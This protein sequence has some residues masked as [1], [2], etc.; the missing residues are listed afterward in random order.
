MSPQQTIL[1]K[2]CHACWEM[3]SV[4]P[5]MEVIVER[6]FQVGI[7]YAAGEQMV[8]N[9]KLPIDVSSVLA[10][11]KHLNITDNVYLAKDLDHPLASSGIADVYKACFLGQTL[12]NEEGN[13]SCLAVKVYRCWDGVSLLLLVL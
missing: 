10:D 2:L 11:M 12:D 7:Q 5:G 8:H 13:A 3:D 1:W 4:R 6:L 9:D